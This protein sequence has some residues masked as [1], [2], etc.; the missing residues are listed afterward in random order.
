MRKYICMICGFVYDEA[1]GIP[2]A[3]IPAETKWEDLPSD[4]VCPLCG[5]TK[6]D[7]RPQSDDSASQQPAMPIEHIDGD[8]REL[9]IGELSALCS[10]LAK[11]CDKQ[12]LGEEAAIFTQLADYFKARTPSIEPSN[13][14]QL[15]ALI[16]QNLSQDFNAAN[17]AAKSIGDRGAQRA[18]VWSEKA[19]RIINSILNRYQS[20]G[21]GFLQRTNIYVCES[22]GFVY[23]GDAPPTLCPVCKVP[24][25][26]FQKIERR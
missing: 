9:T 10:N 22:C 20:E 26:K 5:A 18:L 8:L 25:W 23:V 13:T 3:G 16:N 14:D 15:L 1:V 24:E 11:G 12:H 4:W 21:A 19:T 2:A 6:S 7:F 17:A